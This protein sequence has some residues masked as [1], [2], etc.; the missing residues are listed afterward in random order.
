[1]PH[2]AYQNRDPNTGL[3]EHELA[4]LRILK[5]EGKTRADVMAELGI[6]RQRVA[7]LVAA[8]KAKGYEVPGRS[9]T[10]RADPS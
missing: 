7:Q 8:I 4:T 10:R 5:V 2:P 3:T 1:M 9:Y 6:T